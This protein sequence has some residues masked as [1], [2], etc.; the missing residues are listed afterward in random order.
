MELARPRLNRLQIWAQTNGASAQ[1]SHRT[2][3][4]SVAVAWRASQWHSARISSTS[5]T[6]RRRSPGGGPVRK[7]A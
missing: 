3:D 7:D 4:V 6:G 2:H 1:D 5:W